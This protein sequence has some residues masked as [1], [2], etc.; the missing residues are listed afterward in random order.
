MK[1]APNHMVNLEDTLGEASSF[2]YAIRMCCSDMSSQ[3]GRAIDAVAE[4]I[5]KRIEVARCI[6]DDM[7]EAG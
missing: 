2:A 3:E 4:Q 5:A 1:P 6:I 7:R